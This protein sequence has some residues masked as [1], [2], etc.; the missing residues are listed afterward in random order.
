MDYVNT[1]EHLLSAVRQLNTKKCSCGTE[2]TTVF[3]C[4]IHGECVLRRIPAHLFA[5]A[6]CVGC[7]QFADAGDV[8]KPEPLN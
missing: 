2:L 6:I 5:G 4:T 1:C 7:E 8:A 3:G